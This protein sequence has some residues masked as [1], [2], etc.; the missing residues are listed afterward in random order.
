MCLLLFALQL[1]LAVFLL[2]LL[3]SKP[4]SSHGAL[5]M[6][7]TSERFTLL[8]AFNKCKIQYLANDSVMLFCASKEHCIAAIQNDLIYALIMLY[9]LAHGSILLLGIWESGFRV[10]LQCFI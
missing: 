3:F 6:R 5:R 7:S 10:T 9:L 2:P 4:A 1:Y 8:E